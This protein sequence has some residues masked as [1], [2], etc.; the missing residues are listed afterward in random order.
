LNYKYVCQL[1][2]YVGALLLSL[3]SFFSS[4]ESPLY[5]VFSSNHAELAMPYFHSLLDAL[6]LAKRRAARRPWGQGNP[7]LPG[8][9]IDEY[10]ITDS[11]GYD[12]ANYPGIVYHV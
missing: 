2:F 1:V 12:G 9:Q 3:L 7:G 8:Q 11:G 10:T 4:A 5:G 6:P